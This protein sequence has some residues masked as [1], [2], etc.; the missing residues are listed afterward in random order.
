[1]DTKKARRVREALRN[2]LSLNRWRP[3]RNDSPAEEPQ[4]DPPGPMHLS[5]P[6]G[7]PLP[8]RPSTAEF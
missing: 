3:P 8:E 4:F 6:A 5:H 2:I 7:L 1:M